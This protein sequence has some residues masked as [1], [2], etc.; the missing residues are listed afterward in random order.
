MALHEQALHEQALHEQA[1]HEQ[2][3]QNQT[4][5]THLQVVV[6]PELVQVTIESSP[7]VPQCIKG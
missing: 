4:L 7:V 1:L 2:A 6:Q 3:L 5:H